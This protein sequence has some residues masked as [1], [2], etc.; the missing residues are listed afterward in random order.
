MLLVTVNAPEMLNDRTLLDIDNFQIEAA[1]EFG[2]VT[3]VT[4]SALTAWLSVFR[5][6]VIRHLIER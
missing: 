6:W 5:V 3:E 1:L 2:D 4:A